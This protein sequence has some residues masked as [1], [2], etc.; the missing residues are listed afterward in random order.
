MCPRVH[1]GVLV[2]TRAAAAIYFQNTGGRELSGKGGFLI[3]VSLLHSRV[4]AGLR[5]MEVPTLALPPDISDIIAFRL[6]SDGWPDLGLQQ[7][8]CGPGPS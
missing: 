4:Q 2:R 5:E 1:A 7:L 3:F 8:N 6:H